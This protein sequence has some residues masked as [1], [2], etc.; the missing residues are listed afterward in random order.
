MKSSAGG[1]PL[2]EKRLLLFAYEYNILRTEIQWWREKQR[3]KSALT[4]LLLV[5]LKGPKIPFLSHTCF[6]MLCQAPVKPLKMTL[7]LLS[8]Q[9]YCGCILKTVFI[10]SYN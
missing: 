6:K 10:G 8:W 5:H 4:F 3:N 2:A 1:K 9:L 7:T